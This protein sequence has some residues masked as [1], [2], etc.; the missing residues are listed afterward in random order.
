MGFPDGV[1][2]MWGVRESIH[3]S[4]KVLSHSALDSLALASIFPQKPGLQ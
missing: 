3:A 4:S 1:T 2:W